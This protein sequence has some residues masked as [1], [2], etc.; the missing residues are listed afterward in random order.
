[1]PAGSTQVEGTAVQNAASSLIEA[2]GDYVGLKNSGVSESAQSR[3]LNIAIDRCRGF[4]PFKESLTWEN[5]S[6]T[7]ECLYTIRQAVDHAVRHNPSF[8][9]P[10]AAM[11][12]I[13]GM[14]LFYEGVREASERKAAEATEARAKAKSTK[15]EA[16]G[17]KGTKALPK[18]TI[19]VPD[20]DEESDAKSVSENL[21]ATSPP[22]DQ[23]DVDEDPAAEGAESRAGSGAVPGHLHFKKGEKSQLCTSCEPHTHIPCS[24]QGQSSKKED[25]ADGSAPAPRKTLADAKAEEARIKKKMT[26]RKA[27]DKQDIDAPVKSLVFAVFL[28]AISRISF[29]Y[30]INWL[31]IRG[32]YHLGN[33][34][35]FLSNQEC[36]WQVP[37]SQITELV[38]K[39]V[40][41]EGSSRKRPRTSR[42]NGGD[43]DSGSR[44]NDPPTHDISATV[45]EAGKKAV[46]TGEHLRDPAALAKNEQELQQ[47]FFTCGYRIQH[48]LSLRDHYVELL[49]KIRLQRIANETAAEDDIPA[50]VPSTPCQYCKE[51][52][53]I[54]VSYSFGRPCVYCERRLCDSC[55]LMSAS[56]AKKYFKENHHKIDN[57][58]VFGRNKYS[59]LDIIPHIDGAFY[60][61]R[62]CYFNRTRR[63]IYDA[64]D[65]C[66][67]AQFLHH[68]Y[69]VYS[70]ASPPPR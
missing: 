66:T 12:D 3:M 26:P 41:S 33:K 55:Y 45:I 27:D 30:S 6:Q 52:N 23:M 34:M 68:R 44:P 49:E 32:Q 53:V 57:D 70:R 54:C 50:L 13:Q 2:V 25:S 31:P 64:I 38:T 20:T 15:R 60:Y 63:E 9:F 16:K 4:L 58:F 22:A 24:V 69:S 67:D 62:R 5:H 48:F 1:M 51:D 10:I 18:S 65:A 40:P 19:I 8:K 47:E 7:R 61:L 56:L 39:P 36:L 29:I 59:A 28:C 14:I 42:G 43:G 17:N 11:A 21:R 37:S 46:E 35:V